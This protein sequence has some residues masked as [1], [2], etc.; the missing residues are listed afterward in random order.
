MRRRMFIMAAAML[1]AALAAPVAA[2][3]AGFASDRISVVTKG[4]GPDV[5]L[6]P[7]LGSAPYVWE[8]TVA[9]VPG[10]RYHLVQV[11]GFAGA[12]VGGNKAGPVL[13]PLAEEI[14]RY[15]DEQDLDRPALIGH[16]MGGSL[17]LMV[18]ARHPEAVSKLIVVDMIPFMG[19]MFGPPGTT[20]E[21]IRPTA[22]AVR[23]G[24]VAQPDEKRRQTVAATMAQMVRTEAAR[25]PA[26]RANLASDRGLAARSMHDLIVTDL[27][28][29]L[30][31][32]KVP[33]TVLFVR[34]P[35]IPLTDEQMEAVYKASFAT[36][37]QAELKRIPDAYHFIMAD[38]P[39]RFAA[40]VKAF[41]DR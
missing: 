9:A 39:D 36:L 1:A 15:I 33:V 30:A 38:A 31:A 4:E 32:I 8:G 40:E 27:R 16:S 29:E 21:S 14:A 20:A 24:I 26:V 28:P 18:A 19:A 13:A 17:G 10:Y 41:L 3:A 25:E 12:P 6:I 34:G 23:D 2:F 7:G 11:A 22:D 5:L 35:N 37:P